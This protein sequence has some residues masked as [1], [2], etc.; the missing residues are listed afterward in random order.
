MRLVLLLMAF[1]FSTA[2]AELPTQR[3]DINNAANAEIEKLPGVGPKLAANIIAGRPY[4]LV[5]DLDKVKGIGP[6]LLQKIR[7]YVF[8]VPMRQPVVAA[9]VAPGPTEKAKININSATLTELETLPQIGPKRAEA[10]I[11]GRPFKK[12]DDLLKIPGIKRTQMEELR[13]LV[14]VR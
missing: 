12:V 11:K 2:A 7:P 6:K 3:I 5:D 10:I 13:P 8:I 1:V 4:R 9:A 14:T